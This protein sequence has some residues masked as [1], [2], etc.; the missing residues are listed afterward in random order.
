MLTIHEKFFCNRLRS[1]SS[2][3]GMSFLNISSKGSHMNYK[4]MF[5]IKSDITI[6]NYLCY[7]V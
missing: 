1:F 7:N 5:G 6:T 4:L 2:I 3:E